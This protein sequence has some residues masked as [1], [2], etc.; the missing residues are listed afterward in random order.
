MVPGIEHFPGVAHS[1]DLILE[2]DHLDNNFDR[3][4]NAADAAVSLQLT[5]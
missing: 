1:D 2:W 5:R 3:P 4:L